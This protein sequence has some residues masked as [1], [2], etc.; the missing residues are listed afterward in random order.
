MGKPSGAA[1]S[2]PALT[3]VAATAAPEAFKN[4]L[5]EAT[6]ISSFSLKARLENMLWIERVSKACFVSGH[7]SNRPVFPKH[8]LYQGTTLVVPKKR[9]NNK[10]F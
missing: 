7:D 5:R 10:G 3:H 6:L 2:L 4:V 1:S 8:A 9:Q